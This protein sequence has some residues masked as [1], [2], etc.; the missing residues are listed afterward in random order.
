MYACMCV[1]AR[2]WLMCLD[3]RSY[4]GFARMYVYRIL[5]CRNR[6]CRMF[7][8]VHGKLMFSLPPMSLATFVVFGS[9][10]APFGC[11]V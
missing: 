3:V 10:A 1:L 6:L 9:S 11:L 8:F 7:G 4:V 2:F 5:E